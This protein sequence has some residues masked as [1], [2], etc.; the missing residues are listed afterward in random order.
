M[1]LSLDFISSNG[2]FRFPFDPRIIIFLLFRSLFCQSILLSQLV[3]GV[4][5]MAV[6]VGLVVL[7]PPPHPFQLMPQIVEEGGHKRL[8]LIDVEHPRGGHFLFSIPL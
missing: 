6:V 8:L 7:L 5:G 3:V 4:V 2:R 1:C